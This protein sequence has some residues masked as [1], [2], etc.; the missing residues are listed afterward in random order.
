MRFQIRTLNRQMS[1]YENCSGR[2]ARVQCQNLVHILSREQ[3][4]H[5][6]PEL[7]STLEETGFKNSHLLT[8]VAVEGYHPYQYWA[9]LEAGSGHGAE[10]MGQRTPAD[11]KQTGS[12]AYE[13][14]HCHEFC[15]PSF[16]SEIECRAPVDTRDTTG[17]LP[18]A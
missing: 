13:Q 16:K 4:S 2:W 1:T 17:L 9:V 15:V 3:N 12:I 14:L 6:I 8:V 18:E 11:F 5:Y 10:M 7:L